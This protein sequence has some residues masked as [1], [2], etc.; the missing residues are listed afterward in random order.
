MNEQ[1]SCMKSR[2]V[3]FFVICWRPV[4]NHL[5]VR[6]IRMR[7]RRRQVR[8]LQLISSQ[9]VDL[10]P[11]PSLFFSWL[12][13]LVYTSPI[14]ISNCSAGLKRKQQQAIIEY[15][16]WVSG[17]CWW[18]QIGW[19]PSVVH[20]VRNVMGMVVAVQTGCGEYVQFRL[21]PRSTRRR[22]QYRGVSA[23]VRVVDKFKWVCYIA[24]SGVAID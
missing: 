1:S 21:V 17:W 23:S 4:S 6:S 7:Q 20:T 2:N 22:R 24:A 11:S 5:L 13:P 14:W 18:V 3:F 15:R 8:A 10:T 9:R 16:M 19:L 12:L